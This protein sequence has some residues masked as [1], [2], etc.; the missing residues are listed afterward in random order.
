MVRLLFKEGLIEKFGEKMK[1][2]FTPKPE[3]SIYSNITMHSFD[4]TF[5]NTVA[6]PNKG[7]FPLFVPKLQN[8]QIREL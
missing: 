5:G 4:L 3:V 6:I 8:W 1:Q 7:N 2:N